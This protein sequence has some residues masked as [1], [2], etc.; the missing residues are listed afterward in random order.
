MEKETE[1]ADELLGEV[2]I[3][4]GR[5][6]ESSQQRRDDTVPPIRFDSRVIGGMWKGNINPGTGREFNM[7][8]EA[9]ELPTENLP[10]VV[11]SPDGYPASAPTVEEKPEIRRIL[12]HWPDNVVLALEWHY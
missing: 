10:G 8:R 7:C 6:N 9:S 4:I 5:F 11:I 12:R 3:I 2:D 1:F